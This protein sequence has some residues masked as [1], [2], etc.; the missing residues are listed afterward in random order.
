VW[1][2]FFLPLPQSTYSLPFGYNC[3]NYFDAMLINLEDFRENYDARTLLE[4]DA[5]ANPFLQF[6]RWL[7]AAIEAKLPEPNAMTLA[8]ATPDGKPSA[9]IVLL[10]GVE[11]DGFIFYTNYESHKGR[12]LAAN[13]HAA[14]VF[15]WLEHHRQVRIEGEAVQLKPNL[16]TQYFQS[17]PKGSQ[18]GAWASPQSQVIPDR[19]VL[20]N[21]VIQL[22]DQ[23]KD[24]DQLP[25]PDNWG[26]FILRPTMIEFWQGRPSRLHDRLRYTRTGN[27]WSIDRLAP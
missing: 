10:K 12:Q 7:Q 14:L 20:E 8:T 6:Q 11:S 4:E 3:K 13:P 9:R 18:I 1:Q 15:N 26:G 16:S 17:R 25:R 22:E 21:A 27:S 23:Y 2:G 19:D 24:Q 5:L